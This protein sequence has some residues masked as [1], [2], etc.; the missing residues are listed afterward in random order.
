MTEA[1][2]WGALASAFLMLGA[3]IAY[4]LR[5]SG[6]VIAVVMAVGS[7]LLLGA[8]SFELV[9]DALSTST[10]A[11]VGL[12]VLVG[13]LVFVASN[14]IVASRGGG[15]RKNPRGSDED[16]QPLAIVLGSVLDGV[17]E[18][19]VLGLTVLHGGVSASLL[20][21][22]ALSNFP[23]GMASS[24]GLRARGWSPRRVMLMWA[25][26][27]FVSALASL[28]GYAVLDTASPRVAAYAEA[29][30]A[31]ALLAMLADDLLPQAYAVEGIFTG[32]LVV[33]GFAI[34]IVLAGQ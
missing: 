21:G 20:T 12:L 8:I 9:E 13:S 11:E 26:V 29:F 33:V 1:F 24:S 34:S 6:R 30:A 22:V 18:S 5:P 31:G 19:F 7:G 27:I 28:T 14:W 25:L 32:S 4:E 17:P 16:N 3:F 2:L 23:E 15:Q 10:V